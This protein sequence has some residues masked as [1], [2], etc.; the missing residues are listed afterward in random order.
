MRCS[1]TESVP[2]LLMLVCN[3]RYK[4]I[5][6]GVHKCKESQYCFDCIVSFSIQR[7]AGKQRGVS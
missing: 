2:I 3:G 4:I 6:T 1:V 7:E 5:D